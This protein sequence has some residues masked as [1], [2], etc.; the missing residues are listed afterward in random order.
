VRRDSID[1]RYSVGWQRFLIAVSNNTLCADDD[2]VRVGFISP[3]DVNAFIRQLEKDGIT[4]AHN[5]QA[6]TPLLQEAASI[7]QLAPSSDAATRLS[8]FIS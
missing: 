5:R 4:F 6:M 2:L 8:R 1:A 7:S 3:T